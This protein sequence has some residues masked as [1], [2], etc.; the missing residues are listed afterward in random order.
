M[1]SR[2]GSTT[3]PEVASPPQEPNHLVVVR[4]VGQH[5]SGIR[6]PPPYDDVVLHSASVVEDHG[7]LRPARFHIGDVVT[8]QS[9]EQRRGLGTFDR[10]PPEVTH[11][12]HTNGVA[13][14]VVLGENTLV[15]ERHFPAAEVGEAR[16]ERAVLVVQR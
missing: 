14:R 4:C 7:V 11:I 3:V 1:L 10:Y 8:Q 6:L 13:H 2:S 12:E 5:P 15:L 16:P 9:A